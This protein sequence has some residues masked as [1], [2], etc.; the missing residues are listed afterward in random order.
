MSASIPNIEQIKKWLK[1]E[2]ISSPV[3]PVPIKFLPYFQSYFN[4]I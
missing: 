1:A 2:I 3:K 4:N